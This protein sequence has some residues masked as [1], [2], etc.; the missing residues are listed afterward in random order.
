MGINNILWYLLIGLKSDS[1]KLASLWFQKLKEFENLFC[2]ESLI[3]TNLN[4]IFNSIKYK[5]NGIVELEL[6]QNN[7]RISK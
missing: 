4:H 7:L 6:I 1:F 3:S 5:Q 2:T